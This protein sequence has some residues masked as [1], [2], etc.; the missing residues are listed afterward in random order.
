M[1]NPSLKEGAGSS[2]GRRFVLPIVAVMANQSSALATTN[3]G[4][5]SLKVLKGRRGIWPMLVQQEDD[6]WRW[7]LKKLTMQA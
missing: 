4:T 3:A 7:L 2:T 1:A 6:L 5:K